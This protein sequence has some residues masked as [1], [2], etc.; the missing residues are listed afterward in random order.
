MTTIQR[1][2]KITEEGAAGRRGKVHPT[3]AGFRRL[4]I[5]G[6]TIDQVFDHVFA[7]RARRTNG[8]RSSNGSPPGRRAVSSSRSRV[9]SETDALPYLLRPLET[10]SLAHA[11]LPQ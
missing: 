8:T 4:Q 6:K 3:L 2:Q 5:I 9:T 11:V 1:F 7:D 10:R